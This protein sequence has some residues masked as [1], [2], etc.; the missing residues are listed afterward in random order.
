LG[1]LM[2]ASFA[3]SHRRLC[4]LISFG[5]GTLL[6]VMVFGILPE[7]FAVLNWWQL[8]LALASGYGLFFFVTKY[9]FHVCPACAASH[10]DEA[11]THRFHQI[12]RAMM[13]ALAIHCTMDGLAIAAGHE[14]QAVAGKIAS[15]SI[16]TG[17]CVHK[18]PEGLALGALLLGAGFSRRA[19][20]FRVIAVEST[21]V[22]GGLVGGFFFSNASDFWITI[23]VVHAGGG[24]L[25]LAAHA[26]LGEI[27]KH[28]RALVLKNFAAG[29][30]LIG[31]LVLLL[32]IF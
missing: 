26:V 9:I 29:F 32:R 21:T 22:L 17:I 30:S 6:G 25:Y 14:E 18:I 28:D 27:V 13:I 31:L 11:M 1:G 24:F 7:G 10:F 4:A 20:L 15:F 3:R 12:A 2:G 23:A 16:V 5:A 19:I 8:A